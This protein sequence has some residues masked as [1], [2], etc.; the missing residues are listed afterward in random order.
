M[1]EIFYDIYL[2]LTHHP[3]YNQMTN[4]SGKNQEF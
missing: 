1:S 4:R 2:E 3:K